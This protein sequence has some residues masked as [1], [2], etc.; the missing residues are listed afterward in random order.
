[1]LNIFYR[2][3][4]LQ[5]RMSGPMKVIQSLCQSLDDCDVKYATN[6]EVYK[7]NF[8]I[9]ITCFQVPVFQGS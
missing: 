9:F 6:E 7:H 5:G 4:H 3:S 1:M 2:T 8:F